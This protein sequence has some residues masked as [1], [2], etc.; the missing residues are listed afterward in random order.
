MSLHSCQKDGSNREFP[1]HGDTHLHVKVGVFVRL[2]NLPVLLLYSLGLLHEY[3]W[4]LNMVVSW[5]DLNDILE[6]LGCLW[7]RLIF[8]YFIYFSCSFGAVMGNYGSCVDANLNFS[9][10]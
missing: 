5:V 9:N 7:V 6:L 3:C 8:C 1:W 10:S 2:E 4:F